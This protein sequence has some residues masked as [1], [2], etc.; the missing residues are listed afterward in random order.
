MMTAIG[1]PTTTA[2]FFEINELVIASMIGGC[3]AHEAITIWDAHTRTR[4]AK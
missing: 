2:L 3:I 4:V 1:I